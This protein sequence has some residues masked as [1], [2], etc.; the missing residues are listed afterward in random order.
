MA[1]VQVSLRKNRGTLSVSSRALSFAAMDASVS[2]QLPIASI[3]SQAQN[4][5]NDAAKKVVLKITPSEGDALNFIFIGKD[6]LA[7][8]SVA[9]VSEALA[10]FLASAKAAT[11]AEPALSRFDIDLRSALLLNPK[12][13]DLARLHADLVMTG[14][15]SEHDFWSSRKDILVNQEFA[16]GMKKGVSSAA[17]VDIVKAAS[18]GGSSNNTN[19]DS[20][21]PEKSQNTTVIKFTPEIIH[22]IFVQFPA[23][24][25]AYELHVPEKLSE[26]E[27]WTKYAQSKA[28]HALKAGNSKT[29]STVGGSD[30]IFS[31]SEAEFDDDSLP[32]PKKPRNDSSNKLLD[33]SSTVED[34]IEFGNAPDTT[35]KAGSFRNALP[36]IRRLNRHSTA[37]LKTT[38]ETKNPKPPT[39][40]YQQET[41]LED[42]MPAKVS[43]AR[44]LNIQ[45]TVN[46]FSG[47]SAVTTTADAK[48]LNISLLNRAP[49]ASLENWEPNLIGVAVDPIRAGKVFQAL[50]NSSLKRKIKIPTCKDTF[51]IETPDEIQRIHFQ[52]SELLRHYW[53]FKQRAE[54]ATTGDAAALAQ[55]KVEKLKTAI[56]EVYKNVEVYEK[57]LVS[58]DAKL[59]SAVKKAMANAM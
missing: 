42:L 30:E 29:T 6:P 20:R 21:M 40:V 35:M 53:A 45:Q 32:I 15:I 31:A 56:G 1:Q 55:I 11:G 19:N 48:A 38:G 43:Q 16:V 58:D 47:G 2:A 7:D 12:N 8:R 36:I 9:A 57:N 33:L 52:A 51:K 18:G 41:E 46:Y 27:F 50:N 17:L 10:R 25:R 37:V 59:L 26:K 34:H 49:V 44:Q 24:H 13:K 14:I 28:F 4:I 5:A 3:K 54:T 23:V 39:Q 22:S